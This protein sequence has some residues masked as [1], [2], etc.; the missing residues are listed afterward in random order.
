VLGL[1][2]VSLFI[3]LNATTKTNLEIVYGKQG[4]ERLTYAGVVLTDL[5]KDPSDVFHIWHM[6]SADLKGQPM[7]AGEYGWGESNQG[8][9]WDLTT[10]TW[11]YR[12]AW[13]TIRVGFVQSGNT[14]DMN[15]T[16]TNNSDSNIV[17]HGATIY[18][19]VLR[20][21]GPVKNFGQLAFNT[22]APSVT[23][24]DFGT[25]VVA[26][27]VT[28]PSRPLYSGFE[29]AAAAN[30]YFPIISS[31]AMDSLAA[32][33]PHNDR[34]IRPGE[35]DRFTVSLRFAPAGTTGATI[36]PDAYR[37]WSAS[38]TSD[39][40]WRD[41]RILG[42][43]YLASSPQ[44]DPS[45]PAGY[46]HNPRRYFNESK[47]EHFDTRNAS[48]LAK[49]QA[50]VIRQAK[51]I[52]ENLHKLN[53]Q[54]AIT[55]DI[56]GEQYPQTTSYAC[57]P[58]EIAHLAPEM[59]SAISDS[60]SPYHGMKLDD[61]YFKI[62]KDAGFRTGVCVRP[63]HL[64]L[65]ADGSAQQLYLPDSQAAAELIRKMRFAHERWGATI[66]YVDSDVGPAGERL[67]AK[68]FQ[69][70][71]AAFPDSLVIPE[72]GTPQY[73]AY[74]APFQNF[75]VHSQT[76]TPQ[77]VYNYFPNAF[78]VNMIND[79]SAAKLAQYRAELTDAVR[80]GDVLMVHAGY[81][82]ANNPVVVQIYKDAGAGLR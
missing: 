16:E 6:K 67:D 63:Q 45:Q 5:S 9:A 13:G 27:V 76:G 75:L 65:Y 18:P 1:A 49:F 44:G 46:P 81:W 7:S 55:W 35:T 32:F 20:F 15:V 12:F 53:A 33:L 57:A 19:F 36:A 21:P 50:R 31:T 22:S 14:L 34:P 11:T 48:G 59:E 82:Q 58:D 8:R 62:I 43:V 3:K 4:I 70:V 80:R 72:H 17:F 78:S 47:P 52:V 10:H 26:A 66:F 40:H 25:G 54:G 61:A 71:A 56:E 30:S 29:P 42:T 24:A 79:V 68:L 60:A 37:N 51:D 77:D 69:Q 64:M 23:V 41:R 74:T 73:Y 39:M 38:K 28:D 2:L